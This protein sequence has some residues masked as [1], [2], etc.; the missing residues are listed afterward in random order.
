MISGS[1]WQDATIAVTVLILIQPVF[2]KEIV[3]IRGQYGKFKK[4]EISSLLNLTQD[5]IWPDVMD[6]G[7]M[8]N[9]LILLL[10]MFLV[11]K[12]ILGHYGL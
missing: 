4:L 5:N 6:V 3:I 7:L 1:I 9:T 10:Y 12:V 8:H 2:A 11:Y